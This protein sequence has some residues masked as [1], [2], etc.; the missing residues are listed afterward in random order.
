MD[1]RNGQQQGTATALGEG[2]ARQAVSD[3]VA[4]RLRQSIIGGAIPPNANLRELELAA[5]FNVSRGPIREALKRLEREGLVVSRRNHGAVVAALTLTDLEEIYETRLALEGLAVRHAARKRTLADLA[6]MASVL[7]ELADLGPNAHPTRVAELDIAFH[8]LIYVAAR[9][10]RVEACWMTLKSQ[11]FKSMVSR[12]VTERLFSEVLV[13]QHQHIRA[14]IAARNETE[15]VAAI[16]VHLREAYDRM[17]R[18]FAEREAQ[19]VGGLAA[20]ER[21]PA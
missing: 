19:A 3:T 18:F 20:L 2:P 21:G 5:A 13:A 15:A 14:L 11:V 10:K 1:R 8:H 6:A 16:E 9:H 17:R 7:D 12:N 4:D